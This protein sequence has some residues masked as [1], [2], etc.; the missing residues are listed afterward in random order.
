M[1]W[2]LRGS[3]GTSART[4]SSRS[5]AL[6]A[7]PP[8][9]RA[10]PVA[11]LFAARLVYAINWYNIGAVLPLIGG[12]LHAGPAELGTVIGAF[13][14][15]VGLFQVPAGFASIKFGARRVSLSGLVVLGA[16]GVLSAFAPTWP[17][18]AVIRF[19]GGVGAAFFFSPALSLIASYFPPGRRGPVIGFYNGGFSVGGAVGLIGGAFVGEV[20]GWAATL[21]IGG[22]LLLGTTAVAWFV[23]PRQAEG[24]DRPV[25]KI[26]N[27][28]QPVLWSQSIWALSIGLVGFWGAVYALA[29]YFVSYGHDVHPEWAFGV[30][31]S[32][33]AA[34]VVV[35][36]PGGPIGGWLAERGRDRRVL[37]G[38]F[39]A[40]SG[41]LVFL[42][43][44][45]PL[46]PLAVD[47]IAIG[48]ADGVVFS[49]L[50]LIPSYLPESRGEG[51][52]LGVGL[53]NSI[54]VVVGSGIAIAFGF[55]V[56]I[57][58]YA[59]AWES[60]GV[61]SIVLVPLLVWVRPNRADLGSAGSD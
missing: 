5:S 1:R 18:L 3:S 58:G 6:S 32:L 11:A 59:T 21:G 26:W 29:Q 20:V 40:A 41:I 57:A 33:A 2:P 35:S 24:S 44:F 23:L 19:L 45:L 51:L 25:R 34:V 46:V 39:A 53:V 31:A 7:L 15:G 43:P 10:A 42:I 38:A 47:M 56:A 16:T 28:A 52:A 48:F 14:L 17:I 50:Y 60:V 61:L 37:A 22:A 55:V 36:F 30:A 8:G 12:A 9:E 27:E 4:T 49:I 54:Q 13:L